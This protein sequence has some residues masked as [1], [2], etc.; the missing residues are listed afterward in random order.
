MLKEDRFLEI[1]R[2][3]NENGSLKTKEISDYLSISLATVRR[4]LKELDSLNKIQKV[5]GGA[6]SIKN[7][8]FIN[9]EDDMALKSKLNL[10]EKKLIGQ[11]AASLIKDYDFVYMD[12]GTSVYAMIDFIKAKNLN[13]MTNSIT[14]GK[15]LASLGH[16]VFILPG[17]LKLTTES[18]V[19][20]TT[21]DFLD[22][23]NFNLGFF[24]T[25]GIHK[26]LGFSTPDINEA[27]VKTKAI[28]RSMK[29][30]ILADSSKFG[31]VSQVSFSKDPNIRII[32]N[33][34]EKIV[35]KTY[36]EDL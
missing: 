3:V 17:K 12:S 21:C 26:D 36:K 11:Y 16:E 27:M 29:S 7:A 15:K 10:K 35:S 28:E 31:K 5:F 32:S 25:N 20:A 9:T 34:K 18:L 4:D 23:F 30:F 24:G 6:N 1:I 33:D 2:L 19:G 14:T 22:K 8:Q 13:F